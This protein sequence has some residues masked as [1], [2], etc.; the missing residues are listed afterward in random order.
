MKFLCKHCGHILQRDMRLLSTRRNIRVR[1][2]V[3]Y[4]R[5]WCG[6]AKDGIAL[7]RE[8]KKGATE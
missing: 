3:R 1:R 7:C 6:G 4:Y 8:V 2:G 5:T